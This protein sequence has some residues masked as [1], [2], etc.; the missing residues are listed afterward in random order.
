MTNIFFINI[1]IILEHRYQIVKDV[2]LRYHLTIES[3]MLMCGNVEITLH[4]LYFRPIKVKRFF[5]QNSSLQ[6]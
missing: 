5:L 3:N 1:F 2:F 6:L 4:L